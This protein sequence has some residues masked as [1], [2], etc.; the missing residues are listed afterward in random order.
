MQGGFSNDDGNNNEN[1]VKSQKVLKVKQQ[2]FACVA[3]FLVNF[4]AVHEHQVNSIYATLFSND[5]TPVKFTY[6]FELLFWASWNKRR[7]V[8]KNA[9]SF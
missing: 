4:F 2:I 7:N 8:W 1:N 9:N 3:L 6:L 5:S